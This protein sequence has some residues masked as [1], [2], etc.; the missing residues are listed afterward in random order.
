MCTSL[1]EQRILDTLD[2]R[3]QAKYSVLYQSICDNEL[4]TN[5]SCV[6]K[7]TKI[8]IVKVYLKDNFQKFS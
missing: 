8:K 6:L 3:V 4:G 2:K 1:R 5:T 7:G